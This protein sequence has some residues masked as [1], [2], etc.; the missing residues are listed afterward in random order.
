MLDSSLTSLYS[1]TDSPYVSRNVF[2]L[3]HQNRDYPVR[4]IP[5]GPTLH[6]YSRR[7]KEHEIF[8]EQ[9]EKPIAHLRNFNSP[10]ADNVGRAPCKAR[11]APMFAPS[12][13]INSTSSSTGN[14]FE[15]L[16]TLS[17][18]WYL[19]LPLIESSSTS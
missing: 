1:G 17:S 16:R 11:V 12:S 7:H 18:F 19:E 5:E 14:L 4:P 15:S 13:T 9:L 3:Q 2:S 10:L 6:W 8:E